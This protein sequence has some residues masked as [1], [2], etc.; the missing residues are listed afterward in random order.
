MS[1]IVIRRGATRR[2]ATVLFFGSL[3]IYWISTHVHTHLFDSILHSIQ[4]I[5]STEEPIK[6]LK[7]RKD[8]PTGSTHFG[9]TDFEEG[10]VA[11]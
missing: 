4:I 3:T 9:D 2:G 6:E 8:R 7:S 10:E 5:M 1:C 11:F